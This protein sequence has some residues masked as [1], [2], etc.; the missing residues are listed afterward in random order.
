MCASL[1]TTSEPLLQTYTNHY[2][3]TWVGRKRD[4]VNAPI[5]T[6]DRLGS[7]GHIMVNEPRQLG[8][9]NHHRSHHNRRAM[10]EVVMR[11]NVSWRSI[12]GGMG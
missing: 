6:Y 4:F 9:N 8:A 7:I 1:E 5:Y 10:V 12:V 2:G 3:R 11:N